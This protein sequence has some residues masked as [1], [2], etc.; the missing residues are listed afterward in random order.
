MET[1]GRTSVRN[2]SIVLKTIL[3]EVMTDPWRDQ[4]TR[5]M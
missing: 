5:A 4:M 3:L 1:V 2:P